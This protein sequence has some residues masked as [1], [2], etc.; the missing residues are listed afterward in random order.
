MVKNIGK[1]RDRKIILSRARKI[2][3]D[4]VQVRETLDVLWKD[5][6]RAGEIMR[7]L[8]AENEDL[9]KFEEMLESKDD[10]PSKA[11]DQ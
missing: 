11:G 7:E 9:Y 8:R 2:A 3:R 6:G 1:L 10:T 4:E 5:P